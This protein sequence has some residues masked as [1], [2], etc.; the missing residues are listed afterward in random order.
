MPIVLFTAGAARMSFLRYIILNV[1]GETVWTGGLLATGF[2]L[3]QSIAHISNVIE[4]AS[5]SIL[6]LVA[7][8]ILINLA[9]RAIRRTITAH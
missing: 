1:I 9:Q 5:L 7:L 4:R 6:A 2:F 8:L 3:G